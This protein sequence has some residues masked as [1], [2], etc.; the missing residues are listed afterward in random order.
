VGQ[1]FQR[2]PFSVG[3][4]LSPFVGLDSKSNVDYSGLTGNLALTSVTL[5]YGTLLAA[6]GDTAS[7]DSGLVLPAAIPEPAS[8]MLWGLALAAVAMATVRR[9]R[10]CADFRRRGTAAA[11]PSS[12]L[13]LPRPAD[14]L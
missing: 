6:L 4:Q 10:T 13:R 14:F 1:A 12:G 11:S 3:V 7:F 9:C 8:S 5:A 2:T